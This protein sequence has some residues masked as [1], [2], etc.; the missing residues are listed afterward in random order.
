MFSFLHRMR[1][2][3][4][5][6][7]TDS[8]GEDITDLPPPVT[9]K[10]QEGQ[11]SRRGR[12]DSLSSVGTI[13]EGKLPHLNTRDISAPIPRP[14]PSSITGF[15]NE[16]L[17]PAGNAGISGGNAHHT[18]SSVSTGSGSGVH[19]F[20]YYHQP[21]SLA[22]LHQHSHQQQSS[23][24]VYQ[25]QAQ[26][27]RPY[28]YPSYT[29]VQALAQA[30]GIGHGRTGPSHIAWVSNPGTGIG[31]GC[32]GDEEDLDLAGGPAGEQDRMAN[33]AHSP[34][35]AVVRLGSGDYSYAQE[36]LEHVGYPAD[37]IG[38]SASAPPS[39]AYLQHGTHLHYLPVSSYASTS[40]TYGAPSA[41]IGSPVPPASL[42]PGGA[43]KWSLRL[44]LDTNIEF[45]QGVQSLRLVDRVAAA[46][47]TDVFAG[48]YDYPRA[49]QLSPIAEVD[50]VS[51]DSLKKTKSLPFMCNNGG[52]GTM[53][54]DVSTPVPSRQNT[55]NTVNTT[56]ASPGGSGSQGSEMTRPS[57]IY[58]SPFITRS[59]NRTVSQTS[60]RTHVS[61]ASSSVVPRIATAK[62]NEPPPSL[63]QIDLRPPFPGPHPSQTGS[64]PP[65]RMPK[66]Q[67]R[68]YQQGGV[69]ALSTIIGSEEEVQ[70]PEERRYT[71]DEVASLHAESFV[72]ATS[73]ARNDSGGGPLAARIG[74]DDGDDDDDDEEEEDRALDVSSILQRPPA[75]IEGE[76]R[77]EL[78]SV[79]S[80]RS[81][82]QS[83]S[84]SFIARRWEYDAGFGSGG[85]VPMLRRKRQCWLMATPAF[86]AFWLGFICP[87]LWLIGGWHFT[88][89][90]EQPPRLTFWE[91]YFN[92]G[93][94]KERFRFCLG[95]RKGRNIPEVPQ[96]MPS[97]GAQE[98]ESNSSQ[99]KGKRKE[100]P[101][102][103]RWVA[104]KQPS[105]QRRARLNDPK[106]SL[107]GI[108]FGYPFI[109]RPIPVSRRDGWSG[110]ASSRFLAIVTAP[111]RLFD[112]LYGVK[113]LEV[114]GRAESRRRK[115]DPW[116]QRCRYAFCYALILLSIGLCT[117]STYLIIYNTRQLR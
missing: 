30:H 27:Q 23:T 99:G 1:L 34:F 67:Q 35:P 22:S 66:H 10:H 115:F 41:I 89:F 20:Q 50:Y 36:N 91:F 57:P 58:A 92:A 107:R 60:S 96:G 84:E 37:Q 8:N 94:W 19:V 82:V 31:T 110:R 48:A 98:M 95:R 17:S 111:N 81:H 43:G 109:P 78:V 86:W 61:T 45:S 26:G 79:E 7:S 11:S 46:S 104:E 2:P 65:L 18:S 6:G 3:G 21:S 100:P 54:S 5:S 63:P 105:E 87:F 68:Q 69:G 93:Y 116:I 62:S 101:P 117:A 59:L 12:G 75:S 9:H 106:R 102:V 88:H 13:K 83:G 39:E 49:K 73:Y 16:N 97:E 51:P 112:Q 55:N 28:Q 70:C 15:D 24:S 77:V 90:G 80:G 53:P 33:Y 71:A 25:G 74:D 56:N 38:R 14:S 85:R 108:S 52:S 29:R 76:S 32:G 72:T 40:I 114:R 44:N 4:Y 113:L 47:A 42:T 103:P 64:G